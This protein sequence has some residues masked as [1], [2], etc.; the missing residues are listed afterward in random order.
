MRILYVA[1]LLL[2]YRVA[3]IWPPSYKVHFEDHEEFVISAD[4][5]I[6]EDDMEMLKE[7][8]IHSLDLD[9]DD[10]KLEPLRRL[11]RQSTSSRTQEQKAKLPTSEESYG[12]EDLLRK[13]KRT[14]G[15]NLKRNNTVLNYTSYEREVAKHLLKRSSQEVSDEYDEGRLEIISNSSTT[16]QPMDY[17]YESL[18]S[19][20]YH[21]VLEALHN[22]T[23]LNYTTQNKSEE[24]TGDAIEEILQLQKPEDTSKEAGE[25][26][27]IKSIKWI[28]G[29]NNSNT[30][31]G[32]MQILKILAMI[33]FV[34]LLISVVCWCRHGLCC[35]CFR[36]SFCWPRRLINKAKKYM[37]LNPPGVLVEGG[38]EKRHEP[39]VYE[40]EA[41][42]KLRSSI[43]NL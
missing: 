39:T 33:A 25:N 28:F 2:Q 30:K 8:D 3:C 40:I 29:F 23:S 16:K 19:D 36:C 4:A 35:C 24:T 21:E 18:R 26:F 37:A 34:F 22:N 17:D 11:Y 5:S 1:I 41:Y 15:P 43:M 7:H 14:Q 6:S 9:F 10:S 42:N 20:Y 32:T 27:V 13:R 31:I 12:M 38:K